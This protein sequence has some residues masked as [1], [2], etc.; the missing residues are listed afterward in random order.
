M[1]EIDFAGERFTVADKIGLMPLMRFAKVAKAGVDSAD[2]AGLAALYDLLAQCIADADWA[3]FEAA[4]D[5]SHADGEELMAVIGKVFEA[6]AERPTSR[7]SVSS[8]GP[9]TTPPRSADDSS[10]TVVQRLEQQGRP[11]L[12][13]LVSQSELARSA[14]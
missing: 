8:D 1:A 3:R 5:K 12:A 13:L 9:M 10:S 6:L 2:L 4:A 14:A 11:D 7:P